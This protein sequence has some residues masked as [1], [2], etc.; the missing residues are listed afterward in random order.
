[1]PILTSFGSKYVRT[2]R[3]SSHKYLSGCS[4]FITPITCVCLRIARAVSNSRSS[5]ISN[6][7]WKKKYKKAVT[8]HEVDQDSHTSRISQA[9]CNQTLKIQKTVP[10]KVHRVY[11]S[12]RQSCVL[13]GCEPE[14]GRKAIYYDLKI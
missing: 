11:D 3:C 13:E 14:E 12:S 6:T 9:K 7:I 10:T 5:I 8:S 2:K 1:M 4:C